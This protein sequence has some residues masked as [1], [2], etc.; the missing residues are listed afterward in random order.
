MRVGQQRVGAVFAWD[1]G[2]SRVLNC[3]AI[4]GWAG[5]IVANGWAGDNI[6]RTMGPILGGT[7]RKLL[8]AQVDAARL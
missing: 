7:I 4:G 5:E 6:A 8:G 3:V 2:T 1:N